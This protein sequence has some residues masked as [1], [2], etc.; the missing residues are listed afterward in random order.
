MS[1]PA[2]DL[3]AAGVRWYEVLDRMRTAG[4]TVA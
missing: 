1:T 4:L 3:L 2:E